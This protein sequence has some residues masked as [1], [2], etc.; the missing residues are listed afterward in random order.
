VSALTLRRGVN[1]PIYE[2]VTKRTAR[3]LFADKVPFV[4]CACN[5]HPFGMCGFG[6]DVEPSKYD[7]E[8][9]CLPDS[10]TAENGFRGVRRPYSLDD[11]VANFEFYN[12]SDRETG[13][14]A[15]YY[16]REDILASL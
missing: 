9:V 8:T 6:M 4:M 11:I 7:S 14:Y 16:V 3:K 1:G 15:A 5:L 2:R 13:K 12:C 10:R